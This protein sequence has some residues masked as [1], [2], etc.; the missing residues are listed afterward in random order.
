MLYIVYNLQ[1]HGKDTIYL[2]TKVFS[3]VLVV[4]YLWA[5]HT[6]VDTSILKEKP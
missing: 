4:F 5:S 1:F 3:T 6:F 2:K